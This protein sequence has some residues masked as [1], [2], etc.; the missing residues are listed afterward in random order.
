MYKGRY[1]SVD[2][3]ITDNGI[4]GLV[5]GKWGIYAW[6]SYEGTLITYYIYHFIDG[7]GRSGRDRMVVVF[8]YNECASPLKLLFFS[9]SYS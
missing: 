1:Y 9:L 2:E 4:N 6:D 8:K 7:R 5:C 3:T